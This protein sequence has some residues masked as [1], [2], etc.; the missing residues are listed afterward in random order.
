MGR[1]FRDR[2]RAI[3][4]VQRAVAKGL[5]R[6]VKTLLCVDCGKP[7]TCY[8]HR[9]YGKPLDVEPVCHSCNGIRGPALP[10]G[11]DTYLRR[12]ACGFVVDAERVEAAVLEV[13][14][15]GRYEDSAATVPA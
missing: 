9:N 11:C 8:E 12:F 3:S 2:A 6:P 5:L 1:F 7:A 13:V 15:F 14:D 4:I 10:S